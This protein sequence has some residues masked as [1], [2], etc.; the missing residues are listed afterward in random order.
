MPLHTG[1][2]HARPQR[3]LTPTPTPCTP[4]APP[5]CRGEHGKEST[6]KMYSIANGVVEPAGQRCCAVPLW[7][8]Q[9]VLHRRASHSTSSSSSSPCTRCT[10]AAHGHGQARDTGHRR[11]R[12]GARGTG[13]H[14]HAPRQTLCCG[15][16]VTC[17][18]SC[19]LRPR[20]QICLLPDL[21][22]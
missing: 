9:A 1:R 7:P 17:C 21:D 14:T 20:R 11:G 15:S 13:T 6:L 5:P 22:A 12:P 16:T 2:R 8:V 10:A 18:L 4:A 19:L 3:R